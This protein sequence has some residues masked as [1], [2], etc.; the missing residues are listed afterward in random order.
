MDSALARNKRSVN[1]HS[2]R[3][4]S[5]HRRLQTAASLT[6]FLRFSPAL[7]RLRLLPGW[8]F[9]SLAVNGLLTA[10]LLV[11]VLRYISLTT[12]SSAS[13]VTQTETTENSAAQTTLASLPLPEGALP[14]GSLS[15]GALSEGTAEQQH[16]L[17]YQQWQELL[18]QEAEVAAEQKPDRLTILVG[19][20][21]SLWFPANLLPAKRHWLNQGISGETSNGVLKRL[22]ILDETVPETIFVMI[23]INDLLHGA[24]DQMILD[25]QQEIVR[26]LQTAHP[27]AQIVV[28]SILPHASAAEAT[29]EGRDRFPGLPN[30]RIHRLNRELETIAQEQGVYFLDLYPVFANEQDNLRMDLSTDG[31]HLN[32][33]GYQTWSI[34]LQVYSHEVLEPELTTLKP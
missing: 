28:Q 32:Q 17:N 4:F 30:S 8:V 1:Y 5:H 20:S 29:W 18:A 14:E 7:L 12:P 23:G 9:L 10:V 34:A 26:S 31:L 22:H 33:K 6:H 16:Q 27:Q 19:D 25:N 24:T 15:E 3:P 13:A 21:I 11:L 2:T